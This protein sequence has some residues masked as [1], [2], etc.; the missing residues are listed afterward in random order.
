LCITFFFRCNPPSPF[1]KLRVTSQN[2]CT[3]KKYLTVEE[4]H[5][6]TLRNVLPTTVL[7][8]KFSYLY[9]WP[10]SSILTAGLLE[11]GTPEGVG[12]RERERD[13]EA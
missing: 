13:L 7:V 6:F 9:M 4:C 1:F 10:Y 11:G 2:N 12:G 8:N 3:V 5:D